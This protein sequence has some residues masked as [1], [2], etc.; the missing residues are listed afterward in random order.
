MFIFCNDG[1]QVIPYCYSKYLCYISLFGLATGIIGCYNNNIGLG[2]SVC[3]GTF[4]AVNYW[5]NPIYGYRRTMDI[6]YILYLI[7]IHM[8]YI[9]YSI[10]R[11][12]YYFIQVIGIIFYYLGW[13]FQKNN[14]LSLSIISHCCVHL[15][16]HCYSLLYY[17]YG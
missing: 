2:S 5:R 14:N 10:N 11:I 6:L 15:C 3:I 13:Y 16:A 17:I 12:L 1:T 9:Y 8:Y 4:I 7:S